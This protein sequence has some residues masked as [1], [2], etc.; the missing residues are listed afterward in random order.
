MCL[1]FTA[2]S[3]ADDEEFPIELTCELGN[4][5]LY[6]NITD[7]PETT[8][9]QSHN[10]NTWATVNRGTA[11]TGPVMSFYPMIKQK[12]RASSPKKKK[13]HHEITD[14]YF[15]FRTQEK[16]LSR[17]NKETYS[18]LNRKTGKASLIFHLDDTHDYL[19]SGQCTK[20]FKN[21][22]KNVF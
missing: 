3:W 1:F 14:D 7:N 20:G 12:N 8:W 19:F 5:I 4:L 22:E 6:Y 17:R 9:W 11:T 18:Q 10:S 15:I 21:Y 13:Q 16:P 2:N